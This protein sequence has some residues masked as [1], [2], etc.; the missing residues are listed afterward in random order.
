MKKIVLLLAL[1]VS[2]CLLNTNFAQAQPGFDDDTQDTPIDGG[3]A[4]LVA[5]GI[6]YGVG[7]KKKK[8]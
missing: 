5:S 4:L 8:N 7:L 3:I 6:A 2:F 1:I